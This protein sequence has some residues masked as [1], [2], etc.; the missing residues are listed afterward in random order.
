MSIQEE[1]QELDSVN[2]QIAQLNKQLK[3]WKQRKKE[4]EVSISEY[5]REKDLPGVKFQGKAVIL[6]ER[7]T[8]DRK[9]KKQQEAD[10][11]EVLRRYGINNAEQALHEVMSARRGE[12]KITNKLKLMNYSN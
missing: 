11:I 10:A 1:L 2:K 8:F 5:I 4:L 3:T 7:P 9:K 12:E 6:E